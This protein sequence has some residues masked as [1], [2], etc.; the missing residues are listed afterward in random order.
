MKRC[1]YCDQP[2]FETDAALDSHTERCAEVL[3]TCPTCNGK[4]TQHLHGAS[5]TAEEM[6]EQG[7]E[8]QEDYMAGMFEHPCDLCGGKK[9]LSRGVLLMEAEMAAERRMGA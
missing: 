9:K 3:E 8:F 6:D 1:P 5:F 4:G 2:P 7:P